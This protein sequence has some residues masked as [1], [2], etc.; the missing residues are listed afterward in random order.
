MKINIT[1]NLDQIAFF[2]R[3]ALHAFDFQSPE[4]ARA[5]VVAE[6]T[7]LL[8]YLAK[9]DDGVGVV[10]TRIGKIEGG[11]RL[12][13]SSGNRECLDLVHGHVNRNPAPHYPG[14]GNSSVCCGIDHVG[15][16]VD[17]DAIER[18]EYLHLLGDGSAKR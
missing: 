3:S 8:D 12:E 9:L 4:N 13:S 18:E 2:A 7:A 16:K 1:P 6:M 15:L 5:T 10:V 14:D 17:L 11:I